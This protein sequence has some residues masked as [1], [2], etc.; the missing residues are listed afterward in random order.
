MGLIFIYN[1][2][3]ALKNQVDAAWS[4]ISVQ[5]KRRHDLIPK[6]VEVVQQ[7]ARYEQSILT[8]VTALR[9]ESQKIEHLK[10]S[11]LDKT[12]QVEKTLTKQLNKMIIL[13]ED[14]PD[15]KA[16]QHF[17][18]LQQELSVIEDTLQ[19][20]RR[21]YNGAVRL[22]NTRIDTFPDIAVAKLFNYQY[23]QY[24]QMDIN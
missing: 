11:D 18:E 2:F 16:S 14:Y 20:A 7:Y 19:H 13:A 12:G 15:L 4:D 9:N 23:R 5:L 1:R 3:I 21:F 6:L 24:F 8:S 17:I 22:L 10:N